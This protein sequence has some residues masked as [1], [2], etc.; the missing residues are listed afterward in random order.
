MEKQF[1][2]KKKYMDAINPCMNI[3]LERNK[4]YGNSIDIIKT[5]SI[6]DLCLMKLLRTRELPEDDLKYNDEISD[7][8]NYLVY[9]L[10]RRSD[11]GVKK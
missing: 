11:L 3:A 5:P 7:S 10:M 9:I 6:I 1:V 8:M 2:T 4:R